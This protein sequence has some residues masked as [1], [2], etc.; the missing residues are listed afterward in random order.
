MTPTPTSPTPLLP[1]LALVA[2]LAT[3]ACSEEGPDAYG[4][5]EATEVSVSAEL[6]APLLRFTA[7]E[8]MVLE[9]GAEAGLLDTVPLTLQRRE[10]D[11]Q[12]GAALLGV[13]EAEAQI[14]VVQAQLATAREDRDR[15]ARLYDV[16]AA[17]ARQRTQAEGAVTVLEEQLEAARARVRSARQQTAAMDTRL[18]QVEDRLARSRVTNPVRGTVLAT[19]AEPGEFVQAGRALYTVAPLDTLTLRAWVSGGQLPRV[20][21]GQSVEVQVDATDG[22]LR[23]LPGRV[24]WVASEAEFTPTP[25]QTR[26]ERVAQ[27]YG[28]K[29]RVAN[30]DGLLKIG[31]PGELVLPDGAADPGETADADEREGTGALTRGDVR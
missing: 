25:I 17:T 8:G 18:A 12:R 16:E 2:L 6:S 5:F 23:T 30:P 21:L 26:E 1:T 15:V 3:A 19:Y 4:N 11:A 22:G 24:S 9:A 7:E 28:V 29:V 20:R 10:L 14:G 31:M 27:V 13:A